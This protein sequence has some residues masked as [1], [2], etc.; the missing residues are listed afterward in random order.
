MIILIVLDWVNGQ[1]YRSFIFQEA[2]ALIERNLGV[3]YWIQLTA[4]VTSMVIY[5][6][7]EFI[8]C[9]RIDI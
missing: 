3:D 6:S 8:I 5:R 1:Q 2:N 9:Q 4:I 7:V